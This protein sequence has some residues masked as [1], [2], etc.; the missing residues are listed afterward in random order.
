MNS[1]VFGSVEYGHKMSTHVDG[2]G[3]TVNLDIHINPI[4]VVSENCTKMLQ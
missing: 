3:I 1:H 4:A 2:H